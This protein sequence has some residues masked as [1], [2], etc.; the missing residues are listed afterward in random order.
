MDQPLTRGWTTVVT[1]ELFPER[2][3]RTFDSVSLE[4]GQFR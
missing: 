1:S 2:K 3:P 4:M